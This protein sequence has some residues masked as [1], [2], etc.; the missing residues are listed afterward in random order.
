M[1]QANEIIQPL[2]D[3]VDL[4]ISTE[5]EASLLQLWKRYRVNLNRVDTSLAPDIDWP[6][7][8]ED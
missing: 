8:P 3:A 4:G 6:E 5:K 7:P 2:Q 1:S